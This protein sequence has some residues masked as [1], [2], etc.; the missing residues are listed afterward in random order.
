[1]RYKYISISGSIIIILLLL[2]P[3]A[4][5]AE[6]VGLQQIPETIEDFIILRDEVST[7]P[8]GG[9]AVFVLALYI[10]TLDEKLGLQALT[11][12]LVNDDLHLQKNNGVYKGYSPTSGMRYLLDRVLSKPYMIRSYFAGASP[13]NNYNMGDLPFIVETSTN[14]YSEISE[15][16]IKL[17]VA[18]S[19]AGSPRPVR[20]EL[21]SSG[22]WKVDEFSSLVVGVVPPAEEKRVDDL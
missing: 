12:T 21:N 13:E 22:I 10:Y 6:T 18:C 1:M 16:E 19:G 5:S 3:L 17:F 8:S 11:V 7:T 15:S 4:L 14:K 20:V 2:F 9:A